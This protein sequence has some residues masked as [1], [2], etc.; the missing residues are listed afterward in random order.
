MIT[1][2]SIEVNW[3]PPLEPNGIIKTFEL[4][5]SD[6]RDVSNPKCLTFNGVMSSYNI[7]DLSKY[8]NYYFSFVVCWW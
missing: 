4:C 2:N 3:K 1:S 7:S 6:A 8:L 5:W